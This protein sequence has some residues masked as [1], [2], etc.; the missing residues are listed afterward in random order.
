MA[1]KESKKVI[2]A[3]RSGGI[4]AI[5]LRPLAYDENSETDTHVGEAAHI[6]GEKPG[7]ARY[8]PSMPA[9]E[10]GDVGNLIY[11]CRNCHRIIDDKNQENLWPVERL[12]KLKKDH[13]ETAVRGMTRSYAEVAFGELK[14]AV[15]WIVRQAPAEIVTFDHI[16]LDEK[17]KKN[18]LSNGSK[19]IILHG[20]MSRETVSAYVKMESKLDPDFPGKL[21]AGFLE[22]YYSL[23]KEGEKDDDLFELMCG[24]ATQGFHR[25]VERAA[26]ISVLVYLFEI[27]DVFEK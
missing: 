15:S 1:V 26:G 17:I 2:L 22:R 24:V 8:D 20:L 16:S 27:C 18:E 21:K 4:C 23:R 10:C 25:E 3:F 9:D 14:K 5:C 13:E 7:A 12:L 19:R 6:R 11:L